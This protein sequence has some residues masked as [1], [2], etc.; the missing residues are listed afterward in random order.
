MEHWAQ[1]LREALGLSALVIQGPEFRVDEL[2]L[3]S[4]QGRISVRALLRRSGLANDHCPLA[5]LIG[6]VAKQCF[7]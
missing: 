7:G 2:L 3:V 6:A 1:A 5:L 4:F